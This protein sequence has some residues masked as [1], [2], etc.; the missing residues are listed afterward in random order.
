MQLQKFRYNVNGKSLAVGNPTRVAKWP[1]IIIKIFHKIIFQ[2][3]Q[4][5]NAV[6]NAIKFCTHCKP[7]LQNNTLLKSN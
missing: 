7:L 2:N 4:E 1:Q 5:I 3:F 6:N